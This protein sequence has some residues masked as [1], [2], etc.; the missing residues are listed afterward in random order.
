VQ[1]KVYRVHYMKPEYFRDM[2]CGITKPVRST[3]EQTHVYLRDVEA[4]GLDEVYYRSQGEIWSPNGEAREL[5]RAK[6]LR[7]TS[8]SVGDVIEHDGRFWA[9]ASVGFNELSK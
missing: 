8:M 2:A 5:I 1:S 4:A 6:G 9:V 3:L 7:H